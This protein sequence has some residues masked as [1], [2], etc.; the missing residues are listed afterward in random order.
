VIF[1]R[2]ESLGGL[3]AAL[4]LGVKRLQGHLIDRLA[5]AQ[6]TQSRDDR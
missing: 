5:A 4:A 3:E 2:L 1:T 6:G